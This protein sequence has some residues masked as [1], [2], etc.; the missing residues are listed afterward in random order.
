VHVT[1]VP[2]YVNVTHFTS[3]QFTPLQN[4]I[5]SHILHEFTANHYTSHHFTY[6]HSIPTSIPLLVT[7]FLTLFLKVFITQRKDASNPEGSWFQLVM[8]LFTKEYLPI[9]LFFPSTNIPIMMIPTR[10]T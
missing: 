10:I 9:S 5:T 1:F 6:L 7:T 8:I 2:K 4:K 3:L